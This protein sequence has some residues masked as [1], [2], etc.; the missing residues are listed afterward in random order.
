MG[1]GRYACFDGRDV[2]MG[3]NGGEVEFIGE[4]FG[5]TRTRAVAIVGE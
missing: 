5:R 3:G 2:W 4:R 1:G